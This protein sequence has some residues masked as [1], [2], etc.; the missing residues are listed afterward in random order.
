MDSVYSAVVVG[1]GRIGALYPSEN[2]PRSHSAAYLGNPRVKMIAG[3]DP[4]LEARLEFKKI[5]G[6]NIKLFTSVSEMLS[7]GLR[8]DIVSLCTN[9]DVLQENII[10]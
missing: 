3:I 8:P 7:S 9:P 10:K 4:S 6:K 1:L 5:W 2:I